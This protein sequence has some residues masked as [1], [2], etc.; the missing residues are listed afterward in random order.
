MRNFLA[1]VALSGAAIA[2][3]DIRH[4][5]FMVKNIDP[6]VFPGQYK[7]HMHSFFGSDI[8]TKDLPTT[9][10]LQQ[11]CPSGENPNDLSVY[12]E[13]PDSHSIVAL[14]RNTT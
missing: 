2:Y 14:L 1:V 12:C 9:A 5:R 4:K 6:I 3:T 13:Q 11:G 8:V 10:Q 7:S